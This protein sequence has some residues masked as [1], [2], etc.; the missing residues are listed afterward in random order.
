MYAHVL[1]VKPEACYFLCNDGK[2]PPP[3][4][5]SS[6]TSE[7]LQLVRPHMVM[8]AYMDIDMCASASVHCREEHVTVQNL[9]GHA[10][11]TL[12][13]GKACSAQC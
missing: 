1:H 4:L 6:T 7:C 13:A 3:V 10:R 8:L 2:N 5:H 9:P 11:Y 12:I